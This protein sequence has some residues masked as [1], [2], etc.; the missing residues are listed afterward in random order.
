[1]ANK[2]DWDEIKRK[3][4]AQQ[5]GI[6]YAY[7]ELPPIGTYADQ[8]RVNFNDEAIRLAPLEKTQPI[9]KADRIIDLKKTLLELTAITNGKEWPKFNDK[10][11]DEVLKKMQMTLIELRNLDPTVV[12]DPCCIKIKRSLL[13]RIRKK[14]RKTDNKPIGIY[15]SSSVQLRDYKK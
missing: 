3:K 7:S 10:Y 14:T 6:E 11:R 2:M 12:N 8:K 9:S 5:H 4:R 15:G 1:M 13:N